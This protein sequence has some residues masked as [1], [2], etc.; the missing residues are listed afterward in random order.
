MLAG[1]AE[2][3][4]CRKLCEKLGVEDTNQLKATF[5]SLQT[6]LTADSDNGNFSIANAVFGDHALTIFPSFTTYLESFATHVDTSFPHLAGATEEINAWISNKTMGLITNMLQPQDLFGARMTV[7]NALAFKATW[8][9][10]FDSQK[11]IK[12]YPFEVA[13]NETRP[14]PMMFLEHQ[15]FLLSEGE[16]YMAVR[17]PYAAASPSSQ[18]SLVAYLPDRDSS[19]ADILQNIRNSDIPTN[20]KRTVLSKL[21]LPKFTISTLN[22]VNPMLKE[23]GYPMDGDFPKISP[24]FNSLEQVIHGVTMVVD[25]NGTKAAAVTVVV[26]RSRVGPPSL[27]FDRPFAFSIVADAMNLALFT[28][29]YSAA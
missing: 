19:I 25:E 3:E 13:N 15:E 22:S 27:V 18:M 12:D 4:T 8:A 14:V 2:T 5:S 9:N 20:F 6:L 29:V 17:L 26:T 7:V 28:G 16:G 10:K 21:G 11:T 24:D 1:G 23:L